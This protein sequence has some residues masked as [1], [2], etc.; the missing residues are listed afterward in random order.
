M[1]TLLALVAGLYTVG[2]TVWLLAMR[3]A[4]EGFED[5][6]G[7]PVVWCNN[8][9]EVANVACVWVLSGGHPAH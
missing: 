4:P 9:P 8:D 7:F 5:E 1:I 2:A 6:G 3:S